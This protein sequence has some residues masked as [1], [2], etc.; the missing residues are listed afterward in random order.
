MLR[1]AFV[2]ACLMFSAASGSYRDLQA[3]NSISKY[4][5]QMNAAQ[6]PSAARSFDNLFSM[7]RL[8]GGFNFPGK[9]A[10]TKK[11][12]DILKSLSNSLVY[13]EEDPG[14]WK[15]K[16]KS[17]VP[18]SSLNAETGTI[19]VSLPHP[20]EDETDEKPLHYIEFIWLLS[21]HGD[22][23]DI[24]AFQ[25]TDEAPVANFLITSGSR[26]LSGKTVI[27]YAMCNL[28]GVWRGSPIVVP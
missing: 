18:V 26:S 14:P 2:S 21:D 10:F 12:K 23:L 27:P 7:L 19:Q 11:E 5:Y 3:A 28:H 4:S 8:R 6:A 20:M 13:S 1:V 17:H 16:I 15:E 9:E 25:P 24:H 22:V